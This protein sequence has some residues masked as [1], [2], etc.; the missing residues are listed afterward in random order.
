AGHVAPPLPSHKDAVRDHLE[1]TLEQTN[2]NISHTAAQLGVSRNTVRARI[3]RFGLVPGGSGSLTPRRP[4]KPPVL[5][6]PPA[7]NA[8]DEPAPGLPPAETAAPRPLPTL[9]QT[10]VSSN[11]A[12]HWERRWITLL[13]VSLTVEND[14]DVRDVTKPLEVIADKVQ[15]FGGRVTELGRTGLE[16]AF[17]LDPLED[18]A[19]RAAFAA[20]AVQRAG[21]R[22]REQLSPAPVSRIAL[23]ADSYLV[24][25]IGT[26]VQID[27]EAKHAASALLATLVAAAPPDSTLVS[28]TLLPFLRRRFDFDR[29][30]PAGLAG[31]AHRLLGRADRPAVFDRQMSSFVGRDSEIELLKNRWDL[32]SQGLGQ[33]VGIVGD[34]GVGKSRLIWEFL[35]GGTRGLV[36]ETASIALGRPT[37]YLAIIEMLRMCFGVETGDT[38]AAIRNKVTQHLTDLDP[39]LVVSL[40]AFLSLLDVPTEDSAWDGLDPTRRRRQTFDAIKRLM[41]RESARQPLVLVFED[42]HWADSETKALLESVADSLPVAR[43]LMLVTFRPEYEHG[44]GNRNFYTQVRVDPLRGEG[45]QRFL[46]DLLGDH[47]S[48]DS[49]RARLIEWT[50]G[51]PFFLEETV[52]RLVETGVLEG[53]RGAHRMV[54]P[55]TSISVPKTVHEVLASR[56]ARLPAPAYDVLHLAAVL[57]RRVPHE[58][59]AAVST[60]SAEVLSQGLELLQTREFLSAVDVAE[61][62]EYF[63]RHA[64]TQEVAYA[65]LPEDQRRVLHAQILHATERAYPD[66]LDDRV[67]EL[68]H[69]AF[70]GQQWEKAVGYL[71]SAGTRALARSA[72]TEAAGCFEQ[73]LV[74]LLHLPDRRENKELAID[75]CFGLRNALTPLGQAERTLEH[76]REAEKLARLLGDERRLGRVLSFTANC[77]YI[78]ADYEGAIEASEQARQ[79]AKSLED[80]PLSVAAGMYLGRASAGLGDYGRAA[81]VLRE[82][83]ESLSGERTSDYLGLPVLPAVFARSHLILA[84]AELGE[85]DEAERLIKEAIAI[86]ERT[87]HPETLLWAHVSAGPARLV[88][89]HLGPATAALEHAQGLYRAADIPVYFPLVSSPLGLAYAM[90]GRVP[91]GLALVEQAVERT[92]SRRQAALLPWTLLRLGEVRLLADQASA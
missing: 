6:Q 36:L 67:A 48:V 71:H 14:D 37:P 39:S 75:L 88:R 46:R 12:I 42:A 55:V 52:W 38:D 9:P 43:V 29:P 58:V 84:L 34:P 28:R 50:G 78:M 41:L 83:A 26:W 4:A 65:S 77:L 87:R 74:A 64:L 31:E 63:F 18:A 68:A 92:E 7:A 25:R 30:L 82:I 47:P 56:M 33:V 44:W 61:E 81:D 90:G 8:I 57:G 15:V 72:N 22:A 54:R 91:E 73:A 53:E 66:R 11:A 86:A 70:E 59:L 20:L 80:F 17:G 32:A 60:T 85:F 76:L 2:W 24:G 69:H 49:L 40:P 23:H 51:N 27:Q 5:V 79:H 13:R 62:R 3:E 89:G 1:A 16:A 21:V 10:A 19:Q 35:R 45:A